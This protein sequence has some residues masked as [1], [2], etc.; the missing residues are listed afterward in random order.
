MTLPPRDDPPKVGKVRAILSNLA[1]KVRSA[2]LDWA[3]REQ[4][5]ADERMRVLDEE[6]REAEGWLIRLVTE[7]QCIYEPVG[8]TGRWVYCDDCPLG[9]HDGHLSWGA[10][11]M[12]CSRSRH[13]S[14]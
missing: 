9:D 13:Y 10:Q 4:A 8:D 5:K 6:H 3:D 11:R 7:G 14:K 2:V 1:H 12:L